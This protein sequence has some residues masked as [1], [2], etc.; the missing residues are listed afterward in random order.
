M[1]SNGK[2]GS[3]HSSSTHSSSG[4]GAKSKGFETLGLIEPLLKAVSDSGYQIPTPIQV[5]AIPKLLEGRDLL[6]CAQT[7]TG[8]TGAFALPILQQLARH[9]KKAQPRR[10][11][12]LI[13]TPTRELAV[14]IHDSFCTYGK[15]LGM[16]FGMVFGGV[17]QGL[18]VK[19]LRQGL[20]V[21][22]ATPGRLLDLMGQGHLDL[23]ALEIFVLDEADRMLDMG[24]VRDIRR[25]IEEL[26]PKRQNLFFSATM[27]AEIERLAGTMLVNPVRIE[28]S[29]VSSTAE[30]IDQ[31][32][33]FV[34]RDRKKD[35]LKH[36]LEDHSIYRVIIFTRT[37]HGADNV[38]G[39]LEAAGIEAQSIHGNKSQNA[40]Q[41]ALESFRSGETRVLVA[42]DIAARGIDIDEISHVINFE[43]PNC[44]E[45]YVHRIGRTARAG[46]SGTAISLCA[47]EER[48]FL[49]AI[50]RLIGREIRVNQEQPFHSRQAQGGK[51]VKNSSPGKLR[52]PQNP[53]RNFKKSNRPSQWAKRG[54]S[55]AGAPS[56]GQ[57]P[58]Q[59]L[60]QR[61]GPKNGAKNGPK[62][63]PSV[64]PSGGPKKGAGKN[65][66]S[67]SHHG[68]PNET[69]RPGWR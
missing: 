4:H 59:R 6:G 46:A 39:V 23:S 55:R 14:Q 22:A 27:P 49:R 30:K 38:S 54:E 42:T 68:R 66:K 24:F 45:D 9:P 2:T 29:P 5:Q 17:G 25:V 35:L 19:A 50:E 51:M 64:S 8:K 21:L 20:D 37:K 18:Q 44:P 57:K 40:R 1:S 33:M 7:G 15:H 69:G 12:A 34:D 36:I 63:G 52:P 16:H 41:R 48:G 61:F 31:Q 28:V 65:Q 11:R 58:N 60:D 53:G 56:G 26:P 43:I 47:G 13:L 32:V 62:S 10:P 67:S 3:N